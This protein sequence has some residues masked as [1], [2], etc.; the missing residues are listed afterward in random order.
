MRALDRAGRLDFHFLVLLSF[1]LVLGAVSL[2]TPV[3]SFQARVPQV[4]REN[5]SPLQAPEAWSGAPRCMASFRASL[6]RLRLPRL[7]VHTF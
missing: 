3:L 4:L 7:T 6:P 5:L 2:N 1:Q